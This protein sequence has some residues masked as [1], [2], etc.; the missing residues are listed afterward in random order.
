MGLNKTLFGRL[1]YVF[2]YYLNLFNFEEK[3]LHR[4]GLMVDEG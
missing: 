2:A 3:K 4:V 1:F